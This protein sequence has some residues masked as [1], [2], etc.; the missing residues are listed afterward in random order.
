MN[1]EEFINNSVNRLLSENKGVWTVFDG[2]F[3]FNNNEDNVK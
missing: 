1:R 2:N 3:I